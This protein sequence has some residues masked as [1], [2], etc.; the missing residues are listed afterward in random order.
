MNTQQRELL[1]NRKEELEKQALEKPELKAWIEHTIK[2]IDDVLSGRI[3]LSLI[4]LGWL[5]FI[6]WL[7]LVAP[8][9]LVNIGYNLN[10]E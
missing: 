2:N 5:G 8:E 3:I 10:F 4:V 1:E 9:Y 6:V 7:T